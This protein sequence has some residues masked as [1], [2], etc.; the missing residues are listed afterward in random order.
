MKITVTAV[1]KPLTKLFPNTWTIA[2]DENCINYVEKMK[3]FIFGRETLKIAYDMGL[4]IF[5]LA[6]IKDAPF[7]DIYYKKVEMLPENKKEPVLLGL[8]VNAMYRGRP[9][10]LVNLYRQCGQIKVS[11]PQLIRLNIIDT[12]VDYGYINKK[13]TKMAERNGS[14]EWKLND[15]ANHYMDVISM[16]LVKDYIKKAIN[17]KEFLDKINLKRFSKELRINN[18]PATLKDVNILLQKRKNVTLIDLSDP[19]SRM[20]LSAL[21]AITFK[22]IKMKD[23]F[24]VEKVFLPD[25]PEERICSEAAT[26]FINIIY[27]GN[28]IEICDILVKMAEVFSKMEMPSLQEGKL[29][30]IFNNYTMIYAAAALSHRFDKAFSR[31]EH[32]K[33]AMRRQMIDRFWGVYCNILLYKKYGDIISFCHQV[34]NMDLKKYRDD[35][36]YENSIIRSFEAAERAVR[37]INEERKTL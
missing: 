35:R 15:S 22:D 9:V 24:D 32:L 10:R 36:E 30:D 18:R 12:D 6:F 5:T 34:A 23:I 17:E 16:G 27:N 13:L 19:S 33:L 7:N 11:E 8:L 4:D 31:H 25:S 29:G 20:Y 2:D 28:G 3:E 1:P 14:H 37:E 21:Y 26:E